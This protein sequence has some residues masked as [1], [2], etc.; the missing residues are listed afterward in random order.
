MSNAK[1]R[2]LD[3]DA[4]LVVDGVVAGYGRGD[5]L[6]GASLRVEPG[7]VAGLIG[8]NGSGKTTLVRVASRGLRPVAGTI[9]VGGIDPYAVS[10]RR[11]A[12]AVAV[13]PQALAPAFSFSAL[14]TVLLGRA[15]YQG[16]F[17]SRSVDDW[18]AARWAMREAEV[19]HLA[20]RPVDQ[21]S[22]G[23][24][25]RVFLAQA[26]AQ[27]APV[28][29]LDEPT[30]HLDLRHVG[31]FLGLCRSLAH[32]D[33]RAVLSVFHDL[34]LAAAACERL[35]VLSAGRVVASGAPADVLT[36]ARIAE[37][38]GVD[39]DVSASERTG[40]PMIGF[41]PTIVEPDGGPKD[42]FRS[43]AATD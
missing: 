24:R 11:A 43:V 37:V 38:Y 17:G 10:S 36:R 31:A 9:R 25:Q 34:N 8:P 1:P 42:R 21:L 29:V 19:D 16:P 39:V 5:V 33:G 12:R 30:T 4:G 2:P 23:E 27:D 15:P 32:R 13:V 22:G 20:E 40:R 3:D 7:V 28:L 26:L 41:E 35:F 18:S 14:E 6:R